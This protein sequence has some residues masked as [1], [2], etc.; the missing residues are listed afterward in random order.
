MKNNTPTLTPQRERTLPSAVTPVVLGHKVQAPVLL[1]HGTDDGAQLIDV[2]LGLVEAPGARG[3]RDGSR[4]G[5]G[6]VEVA[7]NLEGGSG[8]GREWTPGGVGRPEWGTCA[9]VLW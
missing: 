6:E 1:V 3:A 5:L 9:G 8:V 7:L 2:D 4:H